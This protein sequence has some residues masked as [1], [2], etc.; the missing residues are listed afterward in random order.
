MPPARQNRNI[1]T[2]KARRLV[3]FG[4]GVFDYKDAHRHTHQQQ[5]LQAARRRRGARLGGEQLWVWESLSTRPHLTRHFL[6][7]QRPGVTPSRTVFTPLTS[8]GNGSEGDA[9]G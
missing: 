5:T 1:Q 6:I 4:N 7:V 9:L 3:F 8:R 2:V